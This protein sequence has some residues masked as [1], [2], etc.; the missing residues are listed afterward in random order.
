MIS[1]YL[2]L[3]LLLLVGYYLELGAKKLVSFKH[4]LY[5]PLKFQI[6]ES[7]PDLILSHVWLHMSFL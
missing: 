1:V 2:I 5:L 3:L 6:L 7:S 4:L